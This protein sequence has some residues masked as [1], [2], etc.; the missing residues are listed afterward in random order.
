MNL[1]GADLEERTAKVAA[2]LGL[3][4][5]LEAPMTSLS[6]GQAARANLAS[7]LLS[8]YDIFLLDEP[9]NDLDID[10]LAILED[11]VV[12]LR[13]GT[14]LVSHDR[15]FLER[16]VDQVLELDLAAVG[17]PVQ[18]RVP[19]VPGRAGDRPAARAERLGD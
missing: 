7:L 5:R 6:G 1:G 11:F 10:G 17:A 3:A 9:T 15:A 8:R 14:V 2:S 12:Q 18:R 4:V 19:R 13:A 16:T